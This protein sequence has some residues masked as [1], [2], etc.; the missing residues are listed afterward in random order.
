MVTKPQLRCWIAGLHKR[1]VDGALASATLLVLA[2]FAMLTR[3]VGIGAI[4]AQ[5]SGGKA[6]DRLP[7]PSTAANTSPRDGSA[8][9][10]VNPWGRRSR[11]FR[12]AQD[13]RLMWRLCA[14][15]VVVALVP[16]QLFAG[17]DGRGFTAGLVNCTEV[18]GFGPIALASVQKLVPPPFTITSFGPS[19]AGLVVRTAQCQNVVLR[20]ALNG[21]VLV[22]QIGVAIS[23]PDG[24]G[25]INNYSLLYATNS[26]ELAEALQETGWPARLDRTLAYEFTPSA[27]GPGGLYIAVS[28]ADGPYF[29]TGSASAPPGP[30]APVV[31]NWWFGSDDGTVKLSTSIPGIAYGPASTILYTSKVTSLG[32][33]IGGNSDT[34]F[35][36]FNGRGVFAAGQLTVSAAK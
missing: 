18:I 27:S 6:S 29:L 34:N 2:V 17:P 16:G 33:I 15:T 12:L 4:W 11:Y 25:D 31:A 23:S 24:T 9:N 35:S 19:T 8:V 5:P 28:P 3:S 1:T 36:F 22:A 32:L 13:Y 14:L 7:E 20:N 10:A 30:P 26:G 21:P